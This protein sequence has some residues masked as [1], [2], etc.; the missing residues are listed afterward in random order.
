M[1]QKP[2]RE[3][4]LR[5]E[6]A[7]QAEQLGRDRERLFLREPGGSPG[8]PVEVDSPAVVEL[9]ARAVPCPRCNGEHAV[10]EHRAVIHAGVRLREVRLKCR[11]CGTERSMWFRLPVLN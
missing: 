7:R 5:R 2:K 8:R 4:T 10:D 11:S 1:S 3:R 9:R 6:A